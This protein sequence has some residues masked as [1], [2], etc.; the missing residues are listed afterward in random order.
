MFLKDMQ[1]NG[2]SNVSLEINLAK[3]YLLFICDHRSYRNAG[4]RHRVRPSVTSVTS[5]TYD[6]VPEVRSSRNHPCECTRDRVSNLR[7]YTGICLEV[8][9]LNIKPVLV[10]NWSFFGVFLRELLL[11][12]S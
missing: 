7:E 1:V 5:R 4:R 6:N 8:D 11:Q 10:K 2:M 12:F 3:R 9:R